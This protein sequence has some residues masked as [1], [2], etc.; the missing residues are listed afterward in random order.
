M[1]LALGLTLLAGALAQTPTTS[2]PPPPSNSVGCVLHGDHYHCDGPASGAS[3]TVSG[4]PPP[5]TESTG[6]T[7]HE[8]HYHCTGRADGAN[9]T[10][11]HADEHDAAHDDEGPCVIHVGHTH[12]KCSSQDIACGAILLEDYKMPLHIAAVFIVLVSSAVGILVPLGAGWMRRSDSAEN[13]TDTVASLDAAALG[14]GGA[15]GKVFFV[16][17]HFGTGIILSTAFIH[18]LYHG[19]VMF[20]NECIGHMGYEST[21][22]AIALAGAFVTFLLDFVGSRTA[23]AKLDHAHARATSAAPEGEDGKEVDGS[24]TLASSSLVGHSCTH[25]EA[26]VRTEQVW[27]VFLLEAGIIFHSIMIGVTL[28]AGSGAGWTTLLIVVVFHQFF[29]GAALGARITLLFWISKMRT[30]VLAIIFTLITP[31]GIAIGIG[32]RKS[33]S[34]NGKAALLSVGILNSISAGIL[35][36]TAFK[37][38]AVDFTDGPLKRAKVSTVCVALGAVIIGMVAMSVLGKWA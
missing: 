37:L 3:S 34:S 14:K 38:L 21:S 15:W 35:L 17:R 36:Y 27:Q 26:V 20:N 28:G 33:F 30:F 25:E 4:I 5:P 22:S 10:A 24:T 9:T 31:I 18:L 16:A 6:C 29:E 1:R 7:L 23:R 11:A 19:F 2:V 12:G 32:V 13:R 8:D